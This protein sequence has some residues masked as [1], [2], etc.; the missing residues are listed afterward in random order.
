MAARPWSLAALALVALCGWSSVASS[1]RLRPPAPAPMVLVLSGEIDIGGDHAG[2]LELHLDGQLESAVPAGPGPFQLLLPAGAG[3]GMV[4]LE[5]HAPGVRLRSL[6]GGQGRL[7]RLAGADATLTPADETGLRVSALSTAISVLASIREGVPPASDAALAAEVQ[8]AWPSDFVVAATALARYALDPGRLPEGFADGLA[9]VEDIDAFN[10]ELLA[11]PSLTASPHLVFDPLPADPL[12]GRDLEPV[13]A[14]VGPRGQ[15]GAP[16]QGP[17]LVL[18]REGQGFRLHGIDFDGP[19]YSGGVDSQE[20]LRMVP[21]Q[22]LATLAGHAPC[23]ALDGQVVMVILR[24]RERDLRRH[25]RGAGAS[26]WQLGTDA[27]F[28]RPDCPGAKPEDVRWIE[29]W[30]SPELPRNRMHD[31]P[32]WLAGQHSLPMFC[33]VVRPHAL[34][35]EACGRADHLLARD[36]TGMAWPPDGAPMAL[37]WG[38]DATGAIRLDYGQGRASRLWLI[39]AGDGITQSLAWVAEAEV[40]GYH[41]TGSGHAIRV[42]GGSGVPARSKGPGVPGAPR[43][44]APRGPVHAGLRGGAGRSTVAR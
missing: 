20:I 39:D 5:Y 29:L 23:E 16:P 10:A 31:A 3:A 19:A 41:G 13:R 18:E 4:S 42:R 44:H 15:P 6:L 2:V 14:L 17:G 37:T 34:D 27:V 32:A 7:T 12:S 8:A 1:A 36:G 43:Y 25:W 11:D 38:R 22:P 24:I 21:D 30:A 33:G 35:V 26:L 28:E 40:V 9:L